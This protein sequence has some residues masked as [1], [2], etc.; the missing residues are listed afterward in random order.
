MTQLQQQV[1]HQQ[2][3]HDD[4]MIAGYE[5]IESKRKEKSLPAK[6][7]NIQTLYVKH[8]NKI[9]VQIPAISDLQWQ[10]WNF[11]SMNIVLALLSLT[12]SPFLLSGFP[13]NFRRKPTEKVLLWTRRRALQVVPPKIGTN[14]EHFK[15]KMLWHRFD[16]ASV[17]TRAAEEVADQTPD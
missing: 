3:Q 15:T 13:C 2:Q 6:T 1:K 12:Y 9:S 11:S 5:A 7:S 4:M 16:R 10:N 8:N 14:F 17:I